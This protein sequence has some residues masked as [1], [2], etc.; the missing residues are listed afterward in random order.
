MANEGIMAAP[1]PM[2]QQQPPRGYVSSLDAY[3]AASSA[4]QETDPQA[5]GEYKTAIGSKLSALN[6]KPS[7]IEAFI[8]LLEY[9]M[10]YPDQY[11]EVIRA[12]IEEG[13]IEEGDFP[14]EFDQG[15]ITTM[16]AALNEQR[17]QQAQNVSPEAMGPGPQEP[18]AMKSGG[19]ADA[20]QALQARG[21]NSDTMLAHI[22]PQEAAMLRRAGGLGT[23]NPYTGLPEY[24]SLKK[25]WK[26]VTAPARAVVNVAKDIAKSPIGRIALG[27]GLTMALGP[28]GLNLG[29][30]MAGTGAVVGG[31]LTA[32]GGGNLQDVLKGAAMGYIG[33]TIAPSISSYMPG[34]AGSVLNQGLTGAALGTGFGL[35]SGMSPEQALKAGA[36]GGVTAAGVGYGQQKGYLPGGQAGGTRTEAPTDAAAEGSNLSL[37]PIESTGGVGT[38]TENLTPVMRQ[39]ALSGQQFDINVGGKNYLVYKDAAGNNQYI[40]SDPIN[41]SQPMTPRVGPINLSVA[42]KYSPYYK[43]ETAPVD[44]F[45]VTQQQLN[46]IPNQPGSTE[47]TGQSNYLLSK[48]PG[49]YSLTTS[50]DYLQAQAMSPG[51]GSGLQDR[52]PVSLS[53]GFNAPRGGVGLMSAGAGNAPGLIIPQ[54]QEAMSFSSPDAV[55]SDQPRLTPQ[56][57]ESYVTKPTAFESFTEG[58]KGLYDRA[59]D[60]V[61]GGYNEYLSPS[62][63]SIQAGNEQAALAGDKAVAA[64]RG[65]MESAGITPTSAGAEAAYDAAYEANAPGFFTKYAPLAAAGLGATYLAG[66]F[67]KPPVD[68]TP[69]YDPTYTGTDY[70]RDNPQAFSGSLYNYQSQG[71]GAYDPTRATLYAGGQGAAV[72]GVVAPTGI[73]QAQYSPEYGRRRTQ[74]LQQYYSPFIGTA[75]PIMAAK[76]GSIREFPRKTG[77]ING[78]GTG[79]SDDIPAMLSDGEF[80]FTARA[81]RNAGNGSRRKGAARMYKLM[82]SLEKGG[83]VKG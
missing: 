23:I 80:V 57:I 10:Q 28:A 46:A 11:K 51:A 58:A 65:R 4:M 71:A 76:G 66:G 56:Q 62:R 63:P 55:A 72:P 52:P 82:K 43:G 61:V 7:E 53:G 69:V 40:R 15:F 2:Q 49:D 18:M 81:V 34:A 6:L 30:G 31:G 60:A 45:T 24:F 12:G 54:Q 25:V 1:M 79:T 3:N 35:A 14:A 42:D 16:L 83:M 41:P 5:F 70:M 64:Y 20:A 17:I 73:M 68:D 22:N 78:P 47:L 74:A 59:S 50:P 37:A 36:I 8:T 75:A 19:L 33:G 38:A 13:A 27:I 67:E 9:M 21:R 77:P 48:P 29:L 32:L 44:N 26:A 39:D